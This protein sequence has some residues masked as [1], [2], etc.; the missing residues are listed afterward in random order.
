MS[1]ARR[2]RTRTPCDSPASTPRD[3]KAK[4]H[5]K[6]EDSSKLAYE[7][8]GPRRVVIMR[9]QYH[10]I[11]SR[12]ETSIEVAPLPPELLPRCMASASTLAMVANTKYC[13]RLPLYRIEQM[14]DRWG[15]PA[16]RGTMSRWL[17]QLGAVFGATIIEAA[18]KQAFANAFC[19]MTDATGFAIQPGPSENGQRR[20]CRKGHYFVSADQ[21]A[22]EVGF[23]DVPS[24]GDSTQQ[25]SADLT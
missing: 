16:D 8:G 6:T 19:I 22:V 17:E 9:V 15:L 12:G 24:A 2:D 21:L 11:D 5:E 10:A 3:G 14:F 4:R 25:Q 18:K 1:I 23:I 7:R 13:D 20:P